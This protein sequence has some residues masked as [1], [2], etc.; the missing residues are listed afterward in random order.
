MILSGP[1]DLVQTL[2]LEDCSALVAI[3]IDETTGKIATASSTKIYVYRPY[4]KEEGLLKV[5][6]IP[7]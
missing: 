5:I 2:Y 1:T 6:A 4:G 3:E 7:S